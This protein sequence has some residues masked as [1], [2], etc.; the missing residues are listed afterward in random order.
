MKILLE[1]DETSGLIT[2]RNGL[3]CSY[4][5]MKGFDPEPSMLVDEVLTPVTPLPEILEM[6]RQGM[7]AEDLIK[8][9]NAKII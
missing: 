1:Y 8:L 6:V 7:S 3:I 2:D 5:G 9:K 4:I